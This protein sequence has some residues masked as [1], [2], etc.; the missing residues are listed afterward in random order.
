MTMQDPIADLLT[1]VR[2]A[3][4]AKHESV[5]LPSSTAKCAICEVLQAEGYI[6]GFETTGDKQPELT[7]SLRYHDGASVIEEIS[8]VSRPGL[9]VYKSCD[10]LPTVRG[11]LGI[12]IVSTNKGVMTAAKARAQGVGGEVLCTVF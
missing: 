2:N 10:E 6:A 3:Q 9:R 5:S 8:R 1:R 12:A 7:I 4:M 11:G